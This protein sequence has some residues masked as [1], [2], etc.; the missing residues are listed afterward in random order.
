MALGE[1]YVTAI[2]QISSLY[3]DSPEQRYQNLFDNF[4]DIAQRIPQYYIAS[5][6]GIKPQSLSRIRKR[7]ARK[8]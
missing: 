2:H 7:L 3:T 1:V 6:V 5:Y 8:H 4:P